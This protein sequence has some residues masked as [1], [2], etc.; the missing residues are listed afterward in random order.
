MPDWQR[1]LDANVS[2]QLSRIQ[3]T[4][5]NVD[6]E[7]LI[8]LD[9]DVA[10]FE[11]T[12]SHKEGVLLTYHKVNGFAPIFCYAGREG[13]MVAN[14]LRPGSQHSGNGALKFL[15]RCIAIMLQAGYEAKELL[16]RPV[17]LSSPHGAA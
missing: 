10:V 4:R 11:D 16:V 14:E 12:F 8:P 13:F 15:K 6:G 9:I 5:I 2:D 7:E 17:A 3:L 1:I